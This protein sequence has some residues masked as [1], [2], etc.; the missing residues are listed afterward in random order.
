VNASKDNV[1]AASAS[2]LPD[3]VAAKRIRSVNADADNI[4]R[5]N[6]ERVDGL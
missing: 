1:R 5:L 3:F 6:I 4:S 2:H